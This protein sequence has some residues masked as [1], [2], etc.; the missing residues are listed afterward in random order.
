MR[1]EVP[2]PVTTITDTRSM[3]PL[4]RG[5]IAVAFVTMSTLALAGCVAGPPARSTPSVA[6]TPSATAAE[7][8]GPR[9]VVTG[10][11]APW[12][13]ALI[14]DSALVSERDSA[15]ILE[16]TPGG[17][18][19]EIGVIEGVVSGGEGGLLGLAMAPDESALY[20]YST[21]EDGNRVQR[22]ALQGEPG[23]L[24]LGT[25]DVVIDG[26]PKAGVHNGGRIAFGPDGALY[27]TTGDAGVPRSAQDPDSLAGKIL[28]LDPD[29][30]VPTDNPFA[31]SPVYSLGHRNVQGLG[32]AADGR[33]FASEFGQDT[34]D[35]LNL[36][37]PGANYGWPDV[38]GAGGADRGFVDPVQEWP[39]DAASPSGLAV[40]DDSIYIANLRGRSLRVVPLD[41]LS[42]STVHLAGTYGRLRSVLEGP[43]GELWIV[44]NNTDGRGDPA[45]GDDRVVALDP[46]TVAF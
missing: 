14:G 34:V 45:D 10:L 3:R 46:T 4:R 23:S 12:S 7:P 8:A 44:T 15:R 27:I 17:D 43:N 25:P 36:I 29:G 22:F 42:A 39:T 13:V 33:M 38:E 37:E 30:G 20:A 28:R 26:L 41:D 2:K 16:F 1:P 18:I 32:W 40:I 19:R 6:A 9:D 31:G 21:A 24:S 5:M 35:E 11:A